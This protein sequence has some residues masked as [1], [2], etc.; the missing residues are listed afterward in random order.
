MR[1]GKIPLYGSTY[2][3]IFL[4]QC[5]LFLHHRHND[6]KWHPF[7]NQNNKIINDYLLSFACY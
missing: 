4:Y 1:V 7:L 6:K 5:I 2:I 3:F